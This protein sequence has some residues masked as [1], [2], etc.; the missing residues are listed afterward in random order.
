MADVP[1][2][3][4]DLLAVG[5]DVEEIPAPLG[6]GPH[7]VRELDSWLPWNVF[8]CRRCGYRAWF[9]TDGYERF[10]CAGE[11]ET[12]DGDGGAEDDRSGGPSVEERRV[13]SMLF[14]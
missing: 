11:P 1:E 9:R 13:S 4:L 2:D 10:A 3:P 6:T 5:E 8:E 7:E 14:R 12:E